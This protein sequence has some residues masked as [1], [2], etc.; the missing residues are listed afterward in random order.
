MRP[1][2]LDYRISFSNILAET[3]CISNMGFI[4]FITHLFCNSSIVSG[5]LDTLVV[6]L[7]IT[8]ELNFASNYVYEKSY[9]LTEQNIIL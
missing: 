7:S 1:V 3:E 2:F 9:N 5:T 4:A 6:L 8:I